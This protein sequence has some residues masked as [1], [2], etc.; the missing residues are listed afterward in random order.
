MNTVFLQII[1][2]SICASY[3]IL[4]IM[5]LRLIFK[6]APARFFCVLWGIAALR[7]VLP[8]SITSNISLIPSVET[9]PYGIEMSPAPQIDS[10]IELIDNA[11]NPIIYDAFV[12]ALANSANPLQILVA[13]GW[14]IW[15]WGGS[16]LIL[17]GIFSYVRL[18]LRLRASI[19][20]KENI[21]YCDNI[22]SPF[23]FGLLRTRIYLP[24]GMPKGNEESVIAHER[25]HIKRGDKYLKPLAFLIL[26]VHWFN[27]FAWIAFALFCRDTERA[28]DEKVI[29]EL[30]KDGKKA[31]SEAL[32]SCSTR[33]RHV[34]YCP[35][36]FGEVSVKSRIRSVLSYKKPA[37]WVL[38]CAILFC[39]VF[40][41][42]FLTS[43]ES[44]P[45][46]KATDLFYV[47]EATDGTLLIE[48]EN[49][50]FLIA[51]YFYPENTVNTGDAVILTH[52]ESTLGTSPE[53][54]K[55]VYSAEL[56]RGENMK[57]VV[58]IS[59]ID[60]RGAL[61]DIKESAYLG[62][63]LSA[64]NITF[65]C[66]DAKFTTDFSEELRSKLLEMTLISSPITK[67]RSEDRDKTY[68]ISL[69]GR[70]DIHF[71]EDF[72]TV[73]LDNGVKPSYSY[74]VLYPEAVRTLFEEYLPKN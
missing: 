21:Y 56:R 59:Q 30:D 65:S 57:T 43:P 70:F 62:L 27:P 14:N 42:F 1:N 71:S 13:V 58:I 7:L 69:D 68:N 37:L 29:C 22:D 72:Q 17:F 40:A 45:Y 9:I 50:S 48:N 28:C 15:L 33:K 11:V 66:G 35:L 12:P 5:F 55:T 10:G 53:S 24:S 25:A 34:L 26:C 19:L 63:S 52:S 36:A 44:S 3:I 39:S 23:I 61:T 41:V 18:Y 74:R 46:E 54:F 47:K 2:T 8:F 6:K 38:I 31:Y 32:L 51:N 49:G 73:W 20:Y 4:L 64:E 67:S 60:R 16:F